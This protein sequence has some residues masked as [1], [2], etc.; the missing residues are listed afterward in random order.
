MANETDYTRTRWT[1]PRGVTFELIEHDYASSNT[2]VGGH[3]FP[4]SDDP[5][6]LAG[7][8]A[9]FACAKP[10]AFVWGEVVMQFFLAH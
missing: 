2:L 10:S 5:G 9:S 8:V 6:G 7:Q 3:C 1:N 4:G